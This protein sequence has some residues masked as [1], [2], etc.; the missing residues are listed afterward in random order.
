MRVGQ[1]CTR[2][3]IIAD[4]SSGI[5]EAA[6]LMREHH[7][8]TLV[9]VE[10]RAGNNRPV[11]IVTDRD[12]VLEVLALGVAP[13]SVTLADLPT[14]ELVVALEEDD[15]LSAL[16]RMRLHGVRRI[17]VVDG[18]DNLVGLLSIDDVL[19]IVDEV[20]GTLVRLIER[21]AGAEVRDR[22]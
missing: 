3:V 15:L 9:V 13:D 2:D 5:T 4:G 21:E 1:L 19:P 12:L 11:G 18:D 20:V 6:R 22:S 17:P 16:E 7:V 10:R 8:G 14:A